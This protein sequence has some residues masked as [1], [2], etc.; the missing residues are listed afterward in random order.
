LN[1]ELILKLIE[2]ARA[3]A[4]NAYCP[5][6]N[7]P[8][9]CSLLVDD[10]IV[11]GGCNVENGVLS[12]SV[13]AGEVAIFKA[14]S[15]GYTKFRAICFWSETKMPYPCGRVRQLLAEFNKNLNMIIATGT[16]DVSYSIAALADLFPFPP[17]SI[18]E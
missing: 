1:K 9:G 15:E 4:E 7:V 17:E 13:S 18:I 2:R 3:S 5:Y 12:T 14:I 6:S 11:I 8:M 10:N 16:A